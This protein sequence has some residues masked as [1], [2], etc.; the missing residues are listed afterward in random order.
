MH[1][2]QVMMG[3]APDDDL[4]MSPLPVTTGECV[5]TVS[6]IGD[7]VSAAQAAAYRHLDRLELPNSPM[8]RTDIGDR[9]ERQLPDLQDDG[10]MKD[11]KF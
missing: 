11:W 3:E 9:I 10:W 5:C 6:G 7:T 4:A 1:L 2:T 8:Y